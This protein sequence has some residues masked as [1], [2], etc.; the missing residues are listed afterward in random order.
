M[1]AQMSEPDRNLFVWTHYRS[2]S[3][4]QVA[5]L[6]ECSVPEVEA[7]L[8]KTNSAIYRRTR[9]LIEQFSRHNALPNDLP[10]STKAVK[11]SEWMTPM[12]RQIRNRP[13]SG[14]KLKRATR[15]NH[16]SEAATEKARGVPPG[17]VGTPA[18]T[19]CWKDPIL[20]FS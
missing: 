19:S 20:S 7:A 17:G 8:H 2:Y 4:Q 5:K 13:E 10:S 18:H 11:P 6:A 15:S 16:G 9:S 3:P 12:P 14:D 1:L